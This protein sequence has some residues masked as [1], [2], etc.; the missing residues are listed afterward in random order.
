MT[1]IIVSG[2]GKDDLEVSE[3]FVHLE[4]EGYVWFEFIHNGKKI[5]TGL[6]KETV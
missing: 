3:L 6:L 5:Q 1:K 4:T 2:C